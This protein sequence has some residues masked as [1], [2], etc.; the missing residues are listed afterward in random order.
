[1]T[2]TLRGRLGGGAGWGLGRARV[3]PGAVPR[4]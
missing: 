3:M 4:R 2:E 1:M